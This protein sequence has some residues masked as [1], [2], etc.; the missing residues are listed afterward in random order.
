[1]CRRTAQFIRAEQQHLWSI[2]ASLQEPTRSGTQRR[3][4]LAIRVVIPVAF[5]RRNLLLNSKLFFPPSSNTCDTNSL[6]FFFLP[7]LR[8]LFPGPFLV[9]PAPALPSRSSS[10]SSSD[11]RVTQFPSQLQSSFP[12]L[13]NPT[14]QH[15][16]PDPVTQTL[17]IYFF[18]L[19]VPAIFPPLDCER[20]LFIFPLCKFLMI[21]PLWHEFLFFLKKNISPHFLGAWRSLITYPL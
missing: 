6:L 14:S 11:S 21:S 12:E 17:F 3:N 9:P 4:V 2:P 20:F 15:P 16:P 18:S 1:M 5:T 7:P 13:F 10:Y 8:D 19:P